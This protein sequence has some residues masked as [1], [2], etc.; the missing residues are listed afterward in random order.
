MSM[1]SQVQE[2]ASD[3]F[4][5]ALRAVRERHGDIFPADTVERF[6]WKRWTKAVA[7]V[8]PT[9]IHANPERFRLEGQDFCEY[10]LMD[11]VLL[12]ERA[13]AL[14]PPKERPL[15]RPKKSAP[16]PL[17]TGGPR[18]FLTRQKRS[19]IVSTH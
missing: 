9:K 5:A 19:G 3:I 2:L 7:R 4:V 15:R 11:E 18:G 14:P 10:V 6:A 17:L 16:V 1:N 12:H 13:K 8:D